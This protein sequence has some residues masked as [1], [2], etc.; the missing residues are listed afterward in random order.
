MDSCF[1]HDNFFFKIRN[2]TDLSSILGILTVDIPQCKVE[3]YQISCHSDSKWNQFWQISEGEKW[4]FSQFWRLWIL[5]FIFFGNFSLENVKKTQKFK[6]HSCSDGQNASFLG[7]KMTK[8]DFTQNPE[9]F[10]IVFVHS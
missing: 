7:F 6:I 5:I 1:A 2:I 4:S 9:K 10:H 3:I 8:I